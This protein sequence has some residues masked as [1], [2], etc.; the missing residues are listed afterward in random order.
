MV[1]F[2]KNGNHT[3]TLAISNT[4]K[5]GSW[6]IIDLIGYTMSLLI[7]ASLKPR[8]ISEKESKIAIS[9]SPDLIGSFQVRPR[10]EKWLL[11]NPRGL[12]TRMADPA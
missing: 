7:G 5:T 3:I 6:Q 11:R 12:G 10:H 2:D 9:S 4:S 1:Q 8:T